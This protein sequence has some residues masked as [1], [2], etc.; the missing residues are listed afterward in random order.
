MLVFEAL[1]E[2]AMPASHPQAQ[3]LGMCSLPDGLWQ[4]LDLPLPAFLLDVSR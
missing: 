2:L 4:K 3:G 1:G